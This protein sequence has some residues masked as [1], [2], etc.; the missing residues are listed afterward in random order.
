MSTV[1]GIDI[2]QN[3][4]SFHLLDAGEIKGTNG[5]FPMTRSGFK[6]FLQQV[7]HVKS[8]RFFM[9]ST[10]RY[11]I[12]LAH[13][14]LQ[15][16]HSAVIVNP[17]LVKQYSKANTLRKTKTDKIDA[18]LIAKYAKQAPKQISENTKAM[19]DQRLSIARRREQVAEQVATVKTQLKAD[20]TVA[21]PE[22]LVHDV[23]TQ[24]MLRLLSSYPCAHTIEKATD[25]QLAAVLK[26]PRGRS[27]ELT[28]QDL[29]KLS[30]DSI[31]IASYGPLVIDSAQSLLFLEQKLKELTKA[32]IALVRETQ[33]MEM[34]IITSVP[35][36]GEITAAHFLAEIESID[37]FERYQN[38]IAFCGTDPSIYESGAILKKGRITKRGNASLR[39]Y[40]YLMGMGAIKFNPFFR[41][42]YDKKREENFPHRKAMVALMNKLIKTLFAM[43]KKKEMYI[44]PT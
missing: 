11:H 32:L 2:S 9:E 1:I 3:S 34:N 8:P 10:G 16:G 36:I 39:K 31:G 7:S 35:G 4:S 28:V 5:S 6:S 40:L 38:L 43:L 21:W 24:G 12:T 42:F 30:T 27:L 22:V 41:A 14:L 37:R 18:E 13:F 26:A 23:F 19:D 15:E 25:E 20:L 33:D 29:R 17:V 44:V